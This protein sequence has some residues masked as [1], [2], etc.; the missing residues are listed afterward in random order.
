V[1]RRRAAWDLQTGRI[2]F[3]GGSAADKI[4]NVR[5]FATVIAADGRV[6]VA[7]DDRVCSP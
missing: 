2:V 5:R 3:G 6:V 4:P 7:G 1:V